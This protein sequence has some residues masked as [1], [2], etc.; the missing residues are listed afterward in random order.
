[1]VNIMNYNNNP[2]NQ[3]KNNQNNQKDNWVDKGKKAALNDENSE[4]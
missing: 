4:D 1:M 3:A 2:M